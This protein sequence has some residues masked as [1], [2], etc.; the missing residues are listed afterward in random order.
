MALPVRWLLMLVVCASSLQPAHTA[1]RASVALRVQAL[2]D[3]TEVASVLETDILALIESAP[4]ADRFDLYR[5]YDQL[6]GAWVQVDLLQS[7]LELSAFAASPAE[8]EE[9]AINLRDHARFALWEL[10]EAR[11]RLEQGAPDADRTEHLRINEAIRSLLSDARS[12]VGRLLADQCA[13][14]QCVTGP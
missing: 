1:E 14:V 12:I 5:T 3:R 7:L 2:Q 9:I 10:D 6:L 8:E 13:R 11:V 4:D